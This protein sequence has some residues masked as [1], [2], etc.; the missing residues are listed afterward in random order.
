VS[1]KDEASANNG[2]ALATV[3]PAFGAK[4]WTVCEDQAHRRTQGA[5]SDSGAQLIE[6]DP[7]K[8]EGEDSWEG[9]CLY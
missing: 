9:S 3:R 1:H 2:F 7:E 4:S 6:L 5:V 8:E